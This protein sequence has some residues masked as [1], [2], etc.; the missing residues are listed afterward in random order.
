MGDSHRALSITEDEWDA[1]MDDLHQSLTKFHVPVEEER[2]LVA[3]VEG[4]K[5]TIVVTPL[6]T[7]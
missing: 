5:E 4:T 2:D 6:R 3:I 1:F 7:Y